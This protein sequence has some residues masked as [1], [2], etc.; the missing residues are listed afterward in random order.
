MMLYDRLYDFLLLF[1]SNK[2]YIMAAQLVKSWS[3]FCK[4]VS[5]E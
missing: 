5:L 1:D 2:V 3:R 4:V